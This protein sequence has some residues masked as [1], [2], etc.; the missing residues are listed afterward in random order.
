[1]T[2]FII[3]TSIKQMTGIVALFSSFTYLLETQE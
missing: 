2:E 1:V 3:F